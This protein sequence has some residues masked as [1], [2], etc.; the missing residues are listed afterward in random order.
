M[1]SG[2]PPE[3][4][5]QKVF[6]AYVQAKDLFNKKLYNDAKIAVDKLNVNPTNAGYPPLKDLTQRINR[7]LG[8]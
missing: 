5:D 1:K 3:P 8:I 6:D 4:P 7:I 2:I